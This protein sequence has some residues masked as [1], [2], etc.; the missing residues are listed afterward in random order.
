MIG[1]IAFTGAVVILATA[2]CIGL[3]MDR[4]RAGRR[5]EVLLT[6]DE[7]RA[8]ATVDFYLHVKDPV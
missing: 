6:A 7:A 8:M 3:F 2:S 4:R 1:W 5:L